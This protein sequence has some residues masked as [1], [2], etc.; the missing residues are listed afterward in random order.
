MGREHSGFVQAGAAIIGDV[1]HRDGLERKVFRVRVDKGQQSSDV[2]LE[3][4]VR[5]GLVT[6]GERAGLKR[7]VE[8]ELGRSTGCVLGG[9]AYQ[10]R[11]P[12]FSAGLDDRV[13]VPVCR[14][15]MF[16]RLS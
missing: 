15:D 5:I 3:N 9:G 6:P 10:R 14:R 2:E 12:S 16:A 8:F 7:F 13:A 1:G 11:Y 4:A